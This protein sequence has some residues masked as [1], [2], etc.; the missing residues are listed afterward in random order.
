MIIRSSVTC[1]VQNPIDKLLVNYEIGKSI[2]LNHAHKPSILDSD[3]NHKV[4]MKFMSILA[5][6][7]RSPKMGELYFINEI[8]NNRLGLIRY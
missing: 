1:R 5:D 7:D 3:S 2:D 4:R 6:M 8:L